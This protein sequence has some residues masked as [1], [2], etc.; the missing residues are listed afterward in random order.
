MAVHVTL[1]VLCVMLLVA[2]SQ[3]KPQ[4]KVFSSS[5]LTTDELYKGVLYRGESHRLASFL[6]KLRANKSVTVYGLGSSVMA[7]YGGGTPGMRQISQGPQT[8]PQWLQDAMN[9]TLTTISSSSNVSVIN[10]GV[11]GGGPQAYSGCFQNTVPNAS[12][13]DLFVL[14]FGVTAPQPGSHPSKLQEMESVVR[15]IWALPRKPAVLFVN[16]NH[17]CRPMLSHPDCCTLPRITNNYGGQSCPS[18]GVANQLLY[19]EKTDTKLPVKH[20]VINSLGSHYNFPV[21]SPT[22]AVQPSATTWRLAQGIH[23]SKITDDVVHPNAY[24]SAIASDLIA[25]FLSSMSLKKPT[26][27]TQ[28]PK[29]TLAPLYGGSPVFTKACYSFVHPANY[30][31][32]GSSTKV[33]NDV[34]SFQEANLRW[35]PVTTMDGWQWVALAANGKAKPGLA[36]S[37]VGSVFEI[38]LDTT[39][40]N[41]AAHQYQGQ[42]FIDFLRSYD[43]MGIVNVTCTKCRCLTKKMQVKKSH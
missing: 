41:F 19:T 17:W 14:E 12:S 36:T 28:G 3:A 18:G 37:S 11:A 1:C 4:P 8:A 9:K 33:A 16:F 24:G 31:G 15:T 38:M 26:K 43:S 20:I 5:T 29:G 10:L 42:V 34:R 6:R 39:A 22:Q 27:S 32:V 21:L 23:L 40:P 7:S 2:P 25:F 35:P 13:V 30:S